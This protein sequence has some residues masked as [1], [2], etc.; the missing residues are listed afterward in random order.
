MKFQHDEIV[1]HSDADL[2]LRTLERYFREIS[3]ET[4]RTGDQLVVYGLGPSF[5]TMNHNDKTIVLATPQLSATMVHTEANFLASALMGDVPQEDIVRSKI[6]RM[7]ES[8]KAELNSGAV[9]HQK[10][11]SALQASE[12]VSVGS[13]NADV[14]HIAKD[15][16]S[17]P[18]EAEQIST[19]PTGDTRDLGDLPE[20]PSIDQ[21]PEPKIDEPVLPPP[22]HSAVMPSLAE[23]ED[24]PA[25]RRWPAVLLLLILLLG[26]GGYFLRHRYSFQS[27][28]ASM[29]GGQAA[30]TAVKENAAA[31]I[32]PSTPPLTN[33]EPPAPAEMPRD[34]KAWVEVWAAAM[35]T[36]DA[37]AQMAFYATPL[38]RYFLTPDVSREQLL[39][40]KQSEI[41][42][43]QGVWTFKAEHVV[44]ENETPTSAV[45]VFIKHIIVGLPSSAIKEQHIKTQLKLK[46]VDG[47]WKIT[48]ERAIY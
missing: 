2:V 3:L 8:L 44:V 18:V 29:S 15:S 21:Q 32:A 27:L 16:P 39:K 5:R 6:E 24:V 1:E 23:M 47:N 46:L 17:P 48:S 43:R 25:K 30:S 20:R 19:L 35:R 12:P 34:I 36:G 13:A 40:D 38:N 14:S 42:S 33:S 31:N 41:E 11:P 26:G 10:A 28:Y 37:Q 4:V 45:V 7:F 22:R 9:S